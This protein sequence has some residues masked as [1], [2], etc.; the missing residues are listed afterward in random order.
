MST[1]SPEKGEMVVVDPSKVVY[2]EVDKT[3]LKPKS[4][5]SPVP[6]SKSLNSMSVVKSH[7]TE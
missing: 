3:R 4:Q 1:P 7:H 5:E 6:D 2:A